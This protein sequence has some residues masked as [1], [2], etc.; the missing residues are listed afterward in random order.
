MNG[1]ENGAVNREGLVLS[2]LFSFV[3]FLSGVQTDINRQTDINP[4]LFI[5]RQFSLL[6]LNIPFIGVFPLDDFE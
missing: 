2:I 3:G 4:A 6:E 5:S 1:G